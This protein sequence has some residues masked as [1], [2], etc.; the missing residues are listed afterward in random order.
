MRACR[1]C[2]DRASRGAGA[3]TY[4]G[5][6]FVS[7]RGTI[8]GVR[9][10]AGAGVPTA[11]AER[12]RRERARQPRLAGGAA[13]AT[14]G[15]ERWQLPRAAPLA[16]AAAATAA[17]GSAARCLPLPPLPLLRGTEPRRRLLLEMRLTAVACAAFAGGV[18]G[19]AAAAH[20]GSAPAV[21][22]D[23]VYDLAPSELIVYGQGLVNVTSSAVPVNL[24][25]HVWTPVARPGGPPVLAKKRPVLMFVHGGAFSGSIQQDKAAVAVPD[26]EYFVQRGFIGITLNYRLVEDD[27]SWPLDWG[28]APYKPSPHAALKPLA[29]ENTTSDWWFQRFH[30]AKAGAGTTTI[31]PASNGELCLSGAGAFPTVS[32]Q[33]C[34]A[35]DC[36]KE[37]HSRCLEGK[38]FQNWLYNEA[39][40]SLSVQP[41]KET[42]PSCLSSSLFSE[43]TA[44]S[45][46]PCNS[47]DVLQ[48]WT[49]GKQLLDGP[50][51]SA[52]NA[53]SCITWSGGFEPSLSRLYPAVRDAKAAVRWIRAASRFNMDADYITLDGGSAGAST[54]IPAAISQIPGDFVS[55]L[56]DVQ[57]P[58]LASTHR[59]ESSS[60]RSVVA[61]WGAAYGVVAVTAADPAMRDR[62]EHAAIA[63]LLP[64]MLEFNQLIDT[65]I[66]IQHALSIQANYH[67][68]DAEGRMTIVPLSHEPHGQF[69][70][71]VTSPAGGTKAQ[72]QVAFA[73]IANDQGLRELVW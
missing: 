68:R 31:T 69:T 8:G 7:V 64:S 6:G 4:P 71:N 33:P 5:P 49:V 48:Q 61:H 46:Q 41:D 19:A 47:S 1:R 18:A 3:P 55:E 37:P 35:A 15:A 29:K 20:T 57:D 67:R 11:G 53:E 30:Y 12:W 59:N 70:A 52:A 40:R 10:A 24:T 44:V 22:A 51:C 43:S 72:S 39:F 34:S 26:V 14:A 9:V 2:D 28:T 58:T 42:R 21:Y 36:A 23:A 65:T 54:V 17:A 45:L 63:S 38:E 73:W 50:I 13:A 32:V 27:A 62:Y 60:V 66:P 56:S 25:A 16:A